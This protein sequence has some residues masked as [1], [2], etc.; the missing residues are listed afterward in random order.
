LIE[1]AQTNLMCPTMNRK[2]RRMAKKQSKSQHLSID[3]AIP[4]AIRLHQDGE[5]KDAEI[6]Y[7][8]VLEAI[9]DHPDALHFLGILMH[10]T[11]HSEAGIKLVTKALA[12]N[13]EYTDAHNNLGNIY[14]QL[15]HLDNAIQAYRKV[16]ALDCKH[17]DALNNL[18]IV[19]KDQGQYQE[20][21]ALFNQVIELDPDNS[22]VYQ[23]L[24]NVYRQQQ[25]LPAAISMYRKAI[26]LRPYNAEAYKYLSHTLY[27]MHKDDEAVQLVNQWLKFDPENP[28]AL[29]TLA[30]YT[31][32]KIPDRASDEY[33][34]QTFDSFAGSFDFVLKRLDY[35]APFLVVD[36]VKKY[37]GEN[38]RAKLAL[39]AGCGTGLCGPL[40]KPFS[41]QLIGIDLSPAMLDKARGR[42]IYDELIQAEL[43]QYLI[44]H[45]ET[46]DLLI[47]ADTLV[48]FGD[49]KPVIEASFLALKA[50]GLIAFTVEKNA[51]EN[52]IQLNPHGRYCHQEG[53]V[54]N[55][56]VEAG[57]VQISIQTAI[58]RSEAGKN[59]DGMV[60]SAR[61]Q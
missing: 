36:A 20:S 19:L 32:Q 49:L 33:V 27:L 17:A 55:L 53:Y 12:V 44:D 61:K 31:G 48:Y 43:T 59:V 4:L 16:L 24:G 21:I 40:L 9:P 60:V 6:L 30:S 25:L 1:F 8:S 5:V 45:S 11:G 56:L 26:A 10:Q 37:L 38:G 58:L 34:K 51:E 54:S 41:D 50:E 46:Y 39:D 7:R 23:N 28:V 35:K 42:K 22:D 15:G 2:Q 47:S 29:H 57:Y 18:G 3:Q 52:A 14:K 13:P